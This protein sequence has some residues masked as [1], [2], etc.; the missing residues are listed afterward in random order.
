M[1][2]LPKILITRVPC[3]RM[4]YTD[5][6]STGTVYYNVIGTGVAIVRVTT[7]TLIKPNGP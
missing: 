3:Q 2:L 7:R 4:R 1:T 5:P 6:E